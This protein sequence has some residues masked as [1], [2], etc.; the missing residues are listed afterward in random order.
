MFM[1]DSKVNGSIFK[2]DELRDIKNH[3]MSAI[4]GITESKLDSSFTDTEINI[5]DYRIIRNDRNRNDESVLYYI[6]NDLCFNTNN[7]ISYFI[8]LF[9]KKKYCPKS[10]GY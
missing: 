4:L 1:L 9:F 5:N 8:E 6:R 2:I 7:I 10:Y 3:K